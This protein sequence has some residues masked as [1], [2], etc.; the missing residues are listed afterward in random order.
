MPGLKDA[1]A[2]FGFARLAAE[3][4][5]ADGPRRMGLHFLNGIGVP[6]NPQAALEWF[7]RPDALEDPAALVNL[8]DMLR[9]GTGVKR[10][11]PRCGTVPQSGEIR[12]SRGH[13]LGR[14]LP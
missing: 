11:S 2:A 13:V 1:E 9:S 7:T 10:T 6:K 12:C 4:G 3:Q 14:Q 5:Y 8:A